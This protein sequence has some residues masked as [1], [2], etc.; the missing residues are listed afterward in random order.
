[1]EKRGWDELDVV[2]ITGDAYVD[3]PSFGAAVIGRMLENRGFRV[4]IIAQPDWRSPEAFAG[5]G[6]PRLFFGITSGNLDSMVANYTAN[7]RRRRVDAYSPGGRTGLRPDRAVIVY[8]NRVREVFGNVP[9]VIGGIEASLRRFAHYDWWD[10]AVRRSILVDSRSDILVYG[11]GERQV[12]EIALR[13]EQHKD[14]HGIAGTV[15][16]GK[17]TAS[18]PQ[19]AEIPSYEDVCR[20]KDLFNE[21]FRVLSA[22]QN[23][24][25]PVAVVQKH[26]GRYV[27]QYPPSLPMETGELDHIY[28]LPYVKACHPV[29]DG[30]GG[31]PGFQ[32]VRS[33][34]ISHRGC[35][36]ECSFCSLSMHQGRIIQSRSQASLVR[37]VRLLAEKDDFKGTVTD[38]GGPTANL[39]MARCTRWNSEGACSDRKCLS[40]VKCRNLKL[41]YPEGL[42]AL[43]ALRALPGV[44]HVFVESGLRYDLLMDEGSR[45][46]LDEICRYHVSGQ[47]K[48]AP[49]H[50]EEGVLHIMNKPGFA[51]YLEFWRRFRESCMRA[52]K[53][54]YLVP[55][56]ISAHPGSTLA[57]TLELSLKLM[58][59]SVYPEQIQ[60]FMPLPLTLSG[61][62]YY[63]GKD[64][65]TG[66]EV[67]VPKTP[68]ERKMHRA[69]I[70][71]RHKGSRPLVIQALKVL[72]KEALA[73]RFAAHPFASEDRYKRR[74]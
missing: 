3:H 67:Y 57:D 31:V 64:P 50:T 34:I 25:A 54:Q 15:I 23:P 52:G 66:K 16:M 55:Y 19:Y 70:Q 60:D 1:M 30:D 73:R 53:E 47:L 49:E 61:T 65:S 46:Y 7:K 32:T 11:M 74:P 45:P 10:N 43:R 35:C 33:S 72:G 26:A 8:A 59:M 24:H 41:G 62:I 69:L 2:L 48:V 6:R 42:K 5:L 56:F 27:I 21:A 17:D 9:V 37:E 71:Y 20:E 18:L 12:V 44:N 58:K 51:H 39:Y 28:E 22:H 63:S 29:Y 4:G 13:L 36:G 38:V 14:L 40:P 68:D